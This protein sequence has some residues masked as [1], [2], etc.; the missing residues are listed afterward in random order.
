LPLDQETIA[1]QLALLAAHRRTLAVYMRQKAELGVLAP[2]GVFNGIADARAQIQR[3]KVILRNSGVSVPDLPDDEPS[4]Q[5][6]ATSHDRRSI[7]SPFQ[8]PYP[9]NPLFV[10][11]RADLARLEA[12]ID[13]NQ[14]VA[15]LPAITGMGGIGKT[16]LAV[17]FAHSYRDRFPGGIFWLDME[18]AK[19]VAPQ[20]AACAGP[21]G[22]NLPN[23]ASLSFDE[24]IATVRAAWQQPDVRLLVFDNLEDTS[25]L[26]QW[27]PIGGGCRVL[28]TTR[29]G[30]WMTTSGVQTIPIDTL[31]RHDSLRLLLAPRT[32]RYGQT[33]EALLSDPLEARVTDAVCNELGDLPL[34]LALAGAYLEV[35]PSVSLAD[36]HTELK[37]ALLEHPSLD[38]PF[39]EGLPTDHITSVA[40]TFQLSYQRL[41]I[42]NSHDILALT[43][44][45]HL[46]WF[47]PTTV[48]HRLILKAVQ[49]NLDS[50]GSK[51]QMDKALRRLSEL[52]LIEL[53]PDNAVRM[54][55]LVSAFARARSSDPQKDRSEVER[56]LI[57]EVQQAKKGDSPQKAL[58]YIEHVRHATSQLVSKSDAQSAL[59]VSTLASLLVAQG[60]FAQAKEYYEKA[61]NINELVFGKNHPNTAIALN[62]LASA[63]QSMGDLNNARLYY[64]QNG[65]YHTDLIFSNLASLLSSEGNEEGARQLYE[66]VLTLREHVLGTNH[67]RTATSLDNLGAILQK[68]G[69][70]V[71][72]KGYHIQALLIREQLLG[73]NHPDIATTL[74]NLGHLLHLEG[75]LDGAQ[76]RYKRALDILEQAFGPNHP[77]VAFGLNSLGVILYYQGKLAEAQQCY[78]RSLEIYD[79]RYGLNYFWTRAVWKHL[80]LLRTPINNA[81]Q[82]T[83]PMIQQIEATMQAPDPDVDLHQHSIWQISTIEEQATEAVRLALSAAG[84][85]E[86][87]ALAIQLSICADWAESR[88]EKESSYV[89][90]AK[91]LCALV[92]RLRPEI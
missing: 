65:S 73:L 23:Y 5:E 24:R 53:L 36:Y 31:A 19:G 40:A 6:I 83:A 66:Q 9:P 38:T 34:A 80:V 27:R 28:I 82:Q 47:A 13:N 46:A 42:T 67:L 56:A 45:H 8:V 26:R 25:I 35:Y 51:M 48:P 43:T 91:Q 49:L 2:P 92:S 37:S 63:L 20:I 71:R 85:R 22:L 59:L 32:R 70:L 17:E 3:I 84:A 18:Q 89:E 1:E 78:E 54:H 33:P 74:L 50:L 29:R 64:E 62:N 87:A 79:Q 81:F 52:G 11:R 72:A 60:D 69:H 61:L 75:D 58:L 12:L 41:D 14:S 55:R 90:L 57:K 86:R 30:T 77:Y 4:S 88:S 7:V 21:S 10:G 68:Q 16:Q 39:E 15:I 44:L 76:S